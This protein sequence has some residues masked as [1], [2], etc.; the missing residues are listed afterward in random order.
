MNIFENSLEPVRRIRR[1]V[2]ERQQTGGVPAQ[3]P[4]F[5]HEPLSS[6]A[7]PKKYAGDLGILIVHG[8]TGSPHSL[9]PLAAYLTGKGYPVELPRLP[10]HGTHWRD[11]AVTHYTD[12]I[13]SVEQA[14]ER[15]TGA[16]YR[17]I[18]I[19]M[20]MGGCL[21]AHLAARRP[22]AGTVLIN[23]FFVDVNPLMRIAHRVAPVMPVMRSIGSD[24]AVPGVDEGAYA[25]TPTA[26]IRQL[27]LLGVETRELLPKLH[28][29]V[30]YLRSV[31]DHTVTDAS[32]RYFLQHV[33]ASVE[34][35]WL[36]RS[37]HVATLDYD[38]ELV[39]EF[40]HKFVQSLS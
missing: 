15:L 38:A 4:D 9:H 11:M 37:Y 35:K 10:G 21:A 27:H 31:S 19:G 8:F 32:H 16:G 39:K 6:P 13:D 5:N 7:D 24:I 34:F 14:Y 25:R 29:P 2:H 28:A 26:S 1:K 20:S 40:T 3:Q 12:W 30:L 17:V 33:S 36:T 22:V 23:P 18:V